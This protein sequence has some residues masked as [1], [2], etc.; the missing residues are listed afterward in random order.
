MKKPNHIV[1]YP[2]EWPASMLKDY[3][4]RHISGIK[5]Q[6]SLFEDQ[7]SLLNK[8]KNKDVLLMHIVAALIL[9]S[10]K[11]FAQ[12]RKFLRE[13][14][15]CTES[16]IACAKKALSNINDDIDAK[17]LEKNLL[18]YVHTL[19]VAP[20]GDI[21]PYKKGGYTSY[22]K[23]KNEEFVFH[24]RSEW[25]DKQKNIYNLLDRYNPTQVLDLGA[26]TGWFSFLAENMGA[27]VIATDVDETV[28]DHIYNS[29]SKHHLNILPLII[30]F[31]DLLEHS[32]AEN[33]RLK[34][35]MVLCLALIHHLVL[36]SNLKLEQIF[37]TLHRLSGRVL[38]VE[39]VD[40]A[41]D[42]LRNVYK[43]P[44]VFFKTEE[45]QKKFLTTWNTYAKEHYNL[46]ALV[47]EGKKY[48]ESVTILESHPQKRK[49]LVFTR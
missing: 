34:S 18:E 48:F 29:A 10:H 12:A 21:H 19:E 31:E 4:E 23:H 20:P 47:N 45:G 27:K 36:V 5:Q 24:D 6:E 7:F 46:D 17:D 26:C 49:L 9:I 15:F 1:S 44:S 33:V 41:D 13:H 30:P 32:E 2:Y 39:Y 14:Q 22:Y 8:T 40:L 11:K 37:E 38:V 16:W 42:V 28:I 43:D 25:L 35:D 3:V